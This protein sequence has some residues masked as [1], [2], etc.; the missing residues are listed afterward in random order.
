[1]SEPEVESL[2]FRRRL[3][4]LHLPRVQ[5]RA[6]EGFSTPLAHPPPPSHAKARERGFLTVSTPFAWPPPPLLAKVSRRWT[7]FHFHA[8]RASSTS[9]P[10]KREP[11]SVRFRRHSCGL[12]LRRVQKRSPASTPASSSLSTTHSTLHQTAASP[13]HATSTTTTRPRAI[14]NNNRV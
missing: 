8:I 14:P 2:L 6:G 10:Y 9:L 7:P 11:D 4:V 3:H 13:I 5:K 1:M 12:H